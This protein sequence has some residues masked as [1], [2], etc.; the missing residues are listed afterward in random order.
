MKS[1][2][3]RARKKKHNFQRKGYLLRIVQGKTKLQQ[4]VACV[5]QKQPV[6]CGL[7]DV[8]TRKVADGHTRG[9]T[10]SHQKFT[11]SIDIF[12]KNSYGALECDARTAIPYSKEREEVH[13]H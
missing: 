8:K 7:S 10:K 12:F 11:L 9:P 6:G 3:C 4:K 2:R 13:R 5:S 1:D